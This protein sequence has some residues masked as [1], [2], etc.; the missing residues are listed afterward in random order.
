MIQTLKIPNEECTFNKRI[1]G[2]AIETYRGQM[3]KQMWLKEDF[4]G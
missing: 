1:I 4:P 2:S 3:G